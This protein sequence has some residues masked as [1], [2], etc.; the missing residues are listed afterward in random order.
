MSVAPV[1][2][3][4]RRPADRERDAAELAPYLPRVALEWL[5]TT[6]EARHRRVEGT[7]LFVDVSGFTALTERL[8]AR[9]KIGAEEITEVIGA[10]F[11]ELLGVGATY[12]ADLLKWGG[13]AVLLSFAGT[14]SA[15]RACRA[16]SLMTRAM[17]RVGRRRTGSGRVALSVSVGAHTGAFD[18][19]LLGDRH[20]ELVI[21]GP[22]ASVTARMEASADAGEVVVSPEAAGHLPPGVVGPAKG[23][24]Y[25]I[26]QPPDA[27]PAP[28]AAAEA[29]GAVDVAALV[30]AD[31]RARLLGGG[32]EAEHR[33]ATVAFIEFSGI[34]ALT[35]AGGGP[36]VARHLDPVI[37]AAQAAAERFGVN[38]HETDIGADGG[39]VV[40]LGGVPLQRGNDAER[41]LRVAHE[42]VAGHPGDSPVRLRAGVNTGRVFV[43]CHEFARAGRRVFAVTGDTVNLAA[44][45]MGRAAPGEVLATRAALD[46]VVHPFETT[47]VPPFRVKGKSQ[48]VAAS[49]VGRPAS[50]DPEVAGE[51][52]A[53][54][55]QEGELTDL[56]R[57]A[58][59][60]AGGSG[61]AVELVGP[62]GIGKS[63]L[64]AEAIRRWPLATLRVACEEYSRS[65]YRPF[66]RLFRRLLAVADDAPHD[67]AGDALRQAVQT[68]APDLVAYLALIGDVVDVPLPAGPEV[69]DLDPRFRRPLL[70][71]CAVQLLRAL[72]AAPTAVVVEDA[73]V[74]DEA[75]ASLLGRLAREAPALPL[76]IVVTSRRAP[77]S[78]PPEPLGSLAI[79]E[80]TPL[81]ERAAT[82]LA[83]AE[84]ALTPARAEAVVARAGGNPLFLRELLRNVGAAGAVD[85]LPER[86]EPLLAAEIDRLAPGDRQVLR[87]A[88]VLGTHVDAALAGAMLDA[89]AAGDGGVWTR[90][91]AFLAPT[92]SGWRFSHGLLRDAAYEG[93]SYRRRRELHGRAARAIEQAATGDEAAEVLSLHWLRAEEWDRTWRYARVAGDRARALWANADAATFYQRAAEA[94]RRLHLGGPDVLAVAEALGDVAEL[95]AA[96]G[97]ARAAYGWG[98]RFAPEAVDRARLLRKLGVLHEREGRYRPALA[99]YS[100]ARTLLARDAAGGGGPRPGTGAERAEL[101]LAS[102]GVMLRE[103]RYRAGI[104]FASA[105]ARD[106]E[107]AGHDRPLA[108]ALY[109][110]HALSVFLGEFPDD[111]AERS[112]GIFERLGDLVGAGNALNNLGISAYY[113]GRW[114]ESRAY[115]ERSRQARARSGDVVGA[116]TEENNIAEILSDQGRFDDARSLLESAR[117]TWIAA[118]YPVGVA[119]ATSNLGRLHARAGRPA[120]ARALLAEAL[121]TFRRLHSAVFVAE[122]E[123]RLAE[124]DVLSG[125]FAAGIDALDRLL[126]AVRGRAGFEH[127]EVA[128][129][130]LHGTASALAAVVAAPQRPPPSWRE[131]FDWAADRAAAIDDPY[132][133]ALALASRGALQQLVAGADRGEG[134]GEA[135][136]DR[137]GELLARLGVERVVVT[138]SEACPGGPIVVT[139]PARVGGD[140]PPAA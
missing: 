91:G 89:A 81:D 63:R 93:L 56:L 135:D 11:G 129:V 107:A 16:A 111:L 132:E 52:G 37:C 13:D 79:L 19:Y 110:Q 124:C 8:A 45:V 83:A 68:L 1:P 35:E 139:L 106:A 138:W 113:R 73:Q 43:F 78:A 137:A 109:L 17:R 51:D 2:S 23:A 90:L 76:L 31:R 54:V 5:A 67:V 101:D 65:P 92:L 97:P 121:A 28:T 71:R 59:A 39:K 64:V 74:I 7:L 44:R 20:R 22:S 94:A 33:Q 100:R 86:L 95:S 125:D 70:E 60:A 103:G 69:R 62:A 126:P 112:L 123:L 6:P 18:L 99:C 87:A 41:A 3:P 104:R 117:A 98:R 32:E 116:A 115:Y 24:G 14:G 136:A 85:D 88:S 82:R 27:D 122:A 118:G 66:R 84:T 77:G 119:L 38:F 25:L 34:D 15:A 61:S 4:S 30:P 29:A 40:L 72:L 9:G 140:G 57:R 10:V 130:R 53:F 36:L 55:G 96:Y 80:L 120:E 46:G 133:L 48:P 12:G 127:T 105:A 75:S 102:A 26:V 49:L 47:E 58:D 131:P 134:S 21:T 108:H 114:T 128:A 42:V 50:A